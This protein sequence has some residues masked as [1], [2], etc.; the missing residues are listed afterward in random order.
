MTIQFYQYQ[1]YLLIIVF[2]QVLIYYFLKILGQLLINHDA[3]LDHAHWKVRCD[4]ARRAVEKTVEE[5]MSYK[6]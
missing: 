4:D 1:V 6:R 3:S 2:F 5:I